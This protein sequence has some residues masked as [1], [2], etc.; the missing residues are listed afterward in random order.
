METQAFYYVHHPAR[1]WYW[2]KLGPGA[3]RRPAAGPKL[4]LGG[5][6]AQRSAEVASLS[7]G[8]RQCPDLP[9]TFS[10]SLSSVIDIPRSTDLHMS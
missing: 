9:P 8:R 5:P 3:P 1:H 4:R 2:A 6:P 10:H 7:S